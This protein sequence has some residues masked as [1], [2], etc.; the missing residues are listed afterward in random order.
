MLF[1]HL[2][3][4]IYPTIAGPEF[5]FANGTHS[6]QGSVSGGEGAYSY[7]WELVKVDQDPQGHNRQLIS[8][9]AS[10]SYDVTGCDANLVLYLTVGSANA[11]SITEY[12]VFNF[13]PRDP[14]V[15]GW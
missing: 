7:R 14:F 13:A 5:V 2:S 15:C 6:W 10:A 12:F 3:S 8:T 1:S 11:T 9:A 4:P